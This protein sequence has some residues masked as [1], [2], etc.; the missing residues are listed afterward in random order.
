MRPPFAALARAVPAALLALAAAA[1]C[2][3]APPSGGQAEP[4]RVAWVDYRSNVLLELV[5]ETHTDR[6]E[7]YSQVRSREDASRK[8]QTD[9]VMDELLRVLR[10]LDFDDHAQPGAM[11]RSGGSTHVMGLELAIGND[12]R[13]MLAWRGM[14]ADDRQAFLEMANNFAEIY[15]ST[16]SLQAVDVGLDESPFENPAAPSNTKSGGKI[17]KAGN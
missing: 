4:L 5:N 10:Q 17:P 14:P 7:R 12:V 3:S 15:N 8:V 6:V 11:P 1:G 16:Y 2:A 9:E 13:H